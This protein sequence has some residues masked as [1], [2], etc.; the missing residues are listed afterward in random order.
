M[1]SLLLLYL[2]ALVLLAYRLYI[3]Q[4]RK[5]VLLL[6]ACIAAGSVLAAYEGVNIAIL[7]AGIMIFSC[8][9]STYH[10]KDNYL[11]VL[12]ALFYIADF[13]TLPTFMAQAMFLG[14]LSGAFFFMKS[15]KD[16]NFR[17]ER[18][19]DIFQILLG[20]ILI[21]AFCFIP[22]AYAKL[23][24]ILLAT[25]AS[26]IGNYAIMNKKSS[27]SKAVYSLERRGAA[28]GQGALWLLMGTLL[29]ISF[30]SATE[31]IAV[32]A[33]IFIGDSVATLVGTTYKS[34]L[35][36]NKKK[37]ISGTLSYFVSAAVLSFPFVGYVGLLTAACAAIVE[38]F[39]KQIDDNFDTAFALTIL[40]KILA[41][42]GLI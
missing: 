1:A 15:N 18:R 21:A 37:S 17:L 32:I 31:V 26:P 22:Q 5:E 42:A 40:I 8:M 13:Y 14:I 6:L 39:P 29:A 33:S 30:L 20:L 25:L 34:P 11:T 7:L 19:R 41:Y 35:P 10:T 3:S 27:V 4:T 24:V 16:R 12:I 38:S 23:M 9:A 36:Y 28:L 2:L